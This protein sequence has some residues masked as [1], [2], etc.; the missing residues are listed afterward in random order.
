MEAQGKKFQDHAFAEWDRN[1]DDGEHENDEA[2]YTGILTCFCDHEIATNPDF[3]K[4]DTYPGRRS[5]VNDTDP[6]DEYPICYTYVS[7]AFFGKMLGYSMSVIIVSTNMALRLIMISLIKWIGED[8]HSSQLKSITNGVFIVQFLN[9]GV[10]LLLVQAN[11][12][13]YDFPLAKSVFNGPFTDFLPLWY[14]GV[15][16][17]IV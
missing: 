7:D 1:F 11:F 9:T 6:D 4:T 8:T 5:G 3:S 13:E 12:I 10:L 2:V 14:V 15:G 17:K 16:Y